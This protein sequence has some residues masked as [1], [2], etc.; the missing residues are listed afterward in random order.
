MKKRILSIITCLALCLCLAPL[1]AAEAEAVE[2]HA[3]HC[4]CGK[5]SSETVDGHT[6][7]ASMPEWTGTATLSND[8]SAGYYYL[9]ANVQ[10]TAPWTPADG[11]VLCLNGHTITA[12]SNSYAM[13]VSNKF[14]L[15]DCS[16]DKTEG[17]LDA[18]Y[19]WHA[20]D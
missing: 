1:L 18:A 13:H 4:V 9:T 7:S 20:G 14:T 19:L 11:T 8:M 2:G 6:H 12:P 5:G 10:L 3:A 15:T 17:Y 16:D